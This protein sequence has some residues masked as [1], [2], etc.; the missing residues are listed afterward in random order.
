MR[1]AIAEFNFILTKVKS[2]L[3]PIILKNSMKWFYA[4]KWN[5]FKD[6]IPH[7][8]MVRSNLF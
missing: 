3:S 4:N 1:E 5:V 6:D 2:L 7:I 8:D